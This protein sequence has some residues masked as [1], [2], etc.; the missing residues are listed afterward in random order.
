MERAQRFGVAIEQLAV[1]G[2]S[3]QVAAACV[4]LGA[5]EAD[6]LEQWLQLLLR[7]HGCF[8]EWIGLPRVPDFLRLFTGQLWH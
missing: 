6:P 5:I 7:T 4:D 3:F 2:S 1:G 8:P